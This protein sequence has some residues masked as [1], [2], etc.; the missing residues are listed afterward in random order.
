MAETINV[1]LG[2]ARTHKKLLAYKTVLTPTKCCTRNMEFL[3]IFKL[4]G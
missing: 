4:T 2:M 1:K 3:R